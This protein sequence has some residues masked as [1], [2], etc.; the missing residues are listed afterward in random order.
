MF[1]KN[2]LYKRRYSIACI[3]QLTNVRQ[4]TINT[5]FTK[6]TILSQ[7]DIQGDLLALPAISNLIMP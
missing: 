4:I 5:V 2:P 7:N 6:W 1:Q 3:N